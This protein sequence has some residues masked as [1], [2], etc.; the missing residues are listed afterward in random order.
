MNSSNPSS[1]PKPGPTAAASP[2]PVDSRPG[3]IGL[4]MTVLITAAV[5]FQ[6]NASMLSPV[7]ATMA[8][9]LNTDEAATG[10]TQTAFFTGGAMCGLFLPRL[11]DIV[12]RRKI[13]V[14]MLGVMIL[15][16]LWYIVYAHRHYFGPRSTMTPELL[17]KL[18]VVTS[19][20]EG[21]ADAAAAA[22]AVPPAEEEE[23]K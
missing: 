19:Q 2:D 16:I 7:L 1:T 9:E 21:E 23:T 5:A 11:S 20:E 3:G 8:R 12:G 18:G 10:L 15:A 22:D 13:L 4:L 14:I 6:L 17:A